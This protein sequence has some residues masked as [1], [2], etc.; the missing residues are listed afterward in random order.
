MLLRASIMWLTMLMM[1]GVSG[2]NMPHYSVENWVNSTSVDSVE[3]Q[4]LLPMSALHGKD[5]RQ[6]D[7]SVFQNLLR[8]HLGHGR[9]RSK[10]E[11]NVRQVTLFDIGL[12]DPTQHQEEEETEWE[13]KLRTFID[14]K[15]SE[16]GTSDLTI[17]RGA[18]PDGFDW[19]PDHA[20]VR[21]A[22]ATTVE[23]KYELDIQ[24]A[25]RDYT[26]A[27][28]FEF[29]R[30]TLPALYTYDDLKFYFPKLFHTRE[31]KAQLA[32]TKQYLKARLPIGE[33]S[34]EWDAE[35]V[36]TIEGVDV[37]F[38]FGTRH[39]SLEDAREG[40]AGWAIRP[41]ELNFRVKRS[42]LS[43]VTSSQAKFL[44]EV[45]RIFN[46]LLDSAWNG[47]QDCGQW[48][49]AK[50]CAPG[51]KLVQGE[52]EAEGCAQNLVE[53]VTKIPRGA[54]VAPATSSPAAATAPATT[55]PAAAAATVPAAA[56]FGFFAP[57]SQA[58][59]S[60]TSSSSS[61]TASMRP[62]LSPPLASPPPAFTFSL[63]PPPATT[64][65]SPRS[66]SSSS[67]SSVST[68]ASSG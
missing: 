52:C 27:T 12:M 5:G 41:P 25:E 23:N 54:G 35:V 20:T 68:R 4:L 24:C 32:K 39:A 47:H 1:S 28:K 30:G 17:K 60:T 8:A 51:F 11:Q 42:A 26:Q 21:D 67:S 13:L 14:G 9:V 18:V 37:T 36:A 38:V 15:P 65:G 66:S 19:Y 10:V 3:Y 43:S 57:P 45:E 49:G 44:S 64:A 33:I 34:F 61:T 48:N 62:P 2:S 63:Q 50:S 22:H 46:V 59:A 58:S 53:P 7:L 6:R 29:A 31:L 16:I 55:T 56:S 40:E